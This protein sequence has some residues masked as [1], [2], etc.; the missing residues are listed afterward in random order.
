VDEYYM[1]VVNPQDSRC[2]LTAPAMTHMPSVTN[3]LLVNFV[4][5]IDCG[6]S[7]TSKRH[8]DIVVIDRESTPFGV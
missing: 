5:N 3:M 2:A 6:F 8:N 7:L 4:V 1:L